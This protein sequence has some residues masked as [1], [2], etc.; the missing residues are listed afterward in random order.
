M[1]RFASVVATIVFVS[2]SFV[3]LSPQ[4]AQA[5]SCWTSFELP[6]Y[7]TGPMTQTYMNCSQSLVFVA[8]FYTLN[9]SRWVFGSDCVGLNPGDTWQWWHA[10]TIQAA[11][12]STTFCS[13][14]NP[15]APAQILF[16]AIDPCWT[17]FYPAA[18]NG[19]P[20]H[21]YYGNCGAGDAYVTPAYVL[22]GSLYV[23]QNSCAYVPAAGPAEPYQE[24]DWYFSTTQVAAATYTT[25][26]C[27]IRHTYN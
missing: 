6:T 18:P 2:I 26:N 11:V 25:V 12:Y 3:A 7:P 5:A 19:Y 15:P 21:Q 13:P 23:Y 24:A 8:P 14:P 17:S 22:A 9:G 10:S 27:I 20:M 16:P 1:K 4:A